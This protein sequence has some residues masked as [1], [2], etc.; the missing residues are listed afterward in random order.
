MADAF[1]PTTEAERTD[2]NK[3]FDY[4]APGKKTA[5]HEYFRAEFKD[6]AV[7][8]VTGVPD[9]RE[10]SLVLTHLEEALFWANA[11]IARNP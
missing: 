10:K 5:L 11:A 1:R 9:G 8:V 3:R 7:A 6:M 4:H 2:L